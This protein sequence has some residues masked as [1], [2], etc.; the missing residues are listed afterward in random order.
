MKWLVRR[1]YHDVYNRDQAIAI[2]NDKVYTGK[3]HAECV[4]RYIEDL[5]EKG[6]EVDN[7]DELY[8]RPEVSEIPYEG[9]PEGG[10]PYNE[11]AFA[12]LTSQGIFLETSTLENMSENEAAS[13]L[14]SYWPNLPIYDDSS[15]YE[16]FNEEDHENPDNYELIVAIRK[17]GYK[18]ASRYRLKGDR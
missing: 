15:C 12:H 8:Y 7:L 9:F 4:Q 6:Y 5:R 14:K 11:V 10:S 18:L 17:V 2:I 1:S 3:T 16:C 13:I